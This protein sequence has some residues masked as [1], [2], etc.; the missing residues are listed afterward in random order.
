MHL[1]ISGFLPNNSDDD[2]VMFELDVEGSF[3]DHI[4]KVLGHKSLSSMAEGE[5]L[6]T[7]EQITLVSG[8]IGQ[9]LPS[10]LKLFIGV[11]V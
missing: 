5:W 2:L 4:L 9:V 1:C 10:D 7:D 11:E 3:N 6:L 8:I